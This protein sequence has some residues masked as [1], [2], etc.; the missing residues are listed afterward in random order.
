[1]VCHDLAGPI[2]SLWA[3]SDRRGAAKTPAVLLEVKQRTGGDPVAA[4]LHREAG[5]PHSGIIP[6]AG[7]KAGK[8]PAAAGGKP[9]SKAP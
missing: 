4:P 5:S 9:G 1:M 7:S 3:V 8:P 6:R 2:F